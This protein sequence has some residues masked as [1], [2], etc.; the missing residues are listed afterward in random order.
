MGQIMGLVSSIPLLFSFNL[1][2]LQVALLAVEIAL[3]GATLL[4]IMATRRENRARDLLL[5]HVSMTTDTI[6]RR[7]HFEAV[8]S[9]IQARTKY[10]YA[11]VTGTTPTTDD[12]DVVKLTLDTIGHASSRGITSR[13]LI[14]DS[15]DRLEMAKL[16]ML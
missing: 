13:Y 10:V 12:A 9:A 2:Y 14:P 7:E 11:M 3:L 16:Y 5:Q 15:P 1:A 8:I 6:F 4:L